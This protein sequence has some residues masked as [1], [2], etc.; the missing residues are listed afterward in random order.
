MLRTRPILGARGAKDESR[1]SVMSR[2]TLND[3]VTPDLRLNSAWEMW[4]PD[5]GPP[6]TLLGDYYKRGMSWGEFEKKYLDYLQTV[7]DLVRDIATVSLERNLTL[8]CIEDT[9][10]FCHRRLI[11]EECKMYKPELIVDIG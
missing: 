2:H 7:Y 1:I 11:A 9:P 4:L 10:E 8:L 6:A 3:G 5:L